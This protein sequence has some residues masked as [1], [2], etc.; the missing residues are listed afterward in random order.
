VTVFYVKFREIAVEQV[1]VTLQNP[2]RIKGIR[3][4]EGPYT[5]HPTTLRY[6]YNLF[7]I[8]L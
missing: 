3:T 8:P 2:I 6:L 5:C 7:Q 1:V 4:G